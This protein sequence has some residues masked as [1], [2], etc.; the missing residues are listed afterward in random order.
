MSSK[1]ETPK[2]CSKCGKNPRAPYQRWCLEC[3]RE[4]SRNYYRTHKEFCRAATKRWYQKLSPEAK[5]RYTRRS[6][7]KDYV[8]SDPEKAAKMRERAAEY[9]KA[10]RQ[11]TKAERRA[12]RKA[13]RE[14]FREY[15]RKYYA[16]H[17]EKIRERQRRRKEAREQGRNNQ[18]SALSQN[19]PVASEV[20]QS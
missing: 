6:S 18:V 2:L 12:Y 7:W 1:T 19:S 13:H 16:A 8:E 15:D 17:R 5:K 4:Y 20:S 10:Y 9:G 3:R 11:R 14:A